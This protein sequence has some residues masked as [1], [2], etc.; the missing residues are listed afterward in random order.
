MV[1]VTAEP[2]SAY[3]F[4][5]ETKTMTLGFSDLYIVSTL[6]TDVFALNLT[7]RRTYE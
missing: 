2:V 4:D 1:D 6:N 3:Q 7:H 5:A